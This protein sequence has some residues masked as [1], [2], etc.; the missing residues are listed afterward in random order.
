MRGLSGAHVGDGVEP[1]FGE[2]RRELVE[3]HVVHVAAEREPVVALVEAP[4]DDLE[5][6]ARKARDAVEQRPRAEP[7][8]VEVEAAE[9][10]AEAREKLLE[11]D[12][13]IF[14]ICQDHEQP[15]GAAREK[16][17]PD[18]MKIPGLQLVAGELVP[19]WRRIGEEREELLAGR[20]RGLRPD[21]GV[22]AIQRLLKRRRVG[23][24]EFPDGTF[25]IS[26]EEA[27]GQ[28]E[29]GDAQLL[30]DIDLVLDDGPRNIGLADE[31][32]VPVLRPRPDDGSTDWLV[33][34]SVF[35][36]IPAT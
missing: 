21:Q 14:A 4:A 2:P 35:V 24:R 11:A 16:N 5:R 13:A 12:P 27:L 8:A 36:R 17:G 3:H 9:D 20:T 30:R 31:I 23:V 32:E 28:A 6:M 26:G 29:S 7:A 15:A 18:V 25:E 22:L 1:H 34:Y 19:P 33:P 10:V